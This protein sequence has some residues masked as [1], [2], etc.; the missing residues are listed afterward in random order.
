M[1]MLRAFDFSSRGVPFLAHLED[2]D[3]LGLCIV[4]NSKNC[5][6]LVSCWPRSCTGRLDHY[7]YSDDLITITGLVEG[8]SCPLNLAFQAG[9]EQQET[10]PNAAHQGQSCLRDPAL[11]ASLKCTPAAL[12]ASSYPDVL[13]AIAGHVRLDSPVGSNTAPPLLTLL[14]LE[15]APYYPTALTAAV[16][17]LGLSPEDL[18]SRLALDY[19]LESWRFQTLV[20][21]G[22][23]T[24]SQAERLGCVEL[25]LSCYPQV[26]RWLVQ[27]CGL[28]PLAARPPPPPRNPSRA[29]SPAGRV[30]YNWNGEPVGETVYLSPVVKLAVEYNRR[31]PNDWES[32]RGPLIALADACGRARLIAHL[33]APSNKH[34]LVCRPRPSVLHLAASQ[35][36]A[37]CVHYIL[38]ELGGLRHIDQLDSSQAGRTAFQ[39]AMHQLALYHRSR[40]PGGYFFT[41]RLGHVPILDIVPTIRVLVEAASNRTQS[42]TYLQAGGEELYLPSYCELT[43]DRFEGAVG[44]CAVSVGPWWGSECS[45]GWHPGQGPCSHHRSPFRGPATGLVDLISLT[46]LKFPILYLAREL[47]MEVAEAEVAAASLCLSFLRSWDKIDPATAGQGLTAL[48][49]NINI[50][51]VLG[52]SLY[53]AHIVA[54]LVAA[55]AV[56]ARWQLGES[57]ERYTYY[58]PARLAELTSVVDREIWRRHGKALAS[59]ACLAIEAMGHA[60]NQTQHEVGIGVMVA[61]FLLREL[62]I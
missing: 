9:T 17:S 14:A 38:H 39:T 62:H 44:V 2:L 37:S 55:G 34:H 58:G 32:Q 10:I 5:A 59:V 22:G 41:T 42:A 54:E 36:S 40:R 30:G 11:P 8:R 6:L 16:G 48:L 20:A 19:T 18:R 28:D 21:L 29:P 4:S 13:V 3:L 56:P 23:T 1:L 61:G 52:D 26:F 50:S 35:L 46:N 47:Q 25:S 60:S 15:T 45:G 33:W 57:V 51:L 24:L 43:R 31:R 27:V 7:L 49:K 53:Q 12:A